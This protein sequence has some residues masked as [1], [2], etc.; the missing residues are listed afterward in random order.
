M[1]YPE[2]MPQYAPRVLH[3]GLFYNIPGTTYKF[4]KHWYRSF[5]PLVCSLSE[6][7]VPSDFLFP[8]PPHPSQLKSTGLDL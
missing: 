6:T 3:Y 1:L 5:E 4:D 8:F 2:Y 7:E